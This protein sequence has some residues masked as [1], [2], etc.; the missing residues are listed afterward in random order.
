MVSF[1]YLELNLTDMSLSLTGFHSFVN[2]EFPEQWTKCIIVPLHKKGNTY[3]ATVR[4]FFV[5]QVRRPYFLPNWKKNKMKSPKRKIYNITNFAADASWM[6]CLVYFNL[7]VFSRI[8]I[9]MC[10][11][12]MPIADSVE[13]KLVQD[14]IFFVTGYLIISSS[15]NNQSL[16]FIQN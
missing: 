14:H 4:W 1:A 10:T 12:K 13:I 3:K 5:S 7:L 15:W 8:E 16:T 9:L 2:G 11:I 6:A